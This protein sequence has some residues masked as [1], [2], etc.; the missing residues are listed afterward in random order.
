M[1]K[2]IQSVQRAATIFEYIAYHAGAGVSELSREL[3]LNKSTV[4]GILKTLEGMGYIFKNEAT[5][6]YQVTYRLRTLADVSRDPHS[7]VGFARPIL[8][9]LQEKHDETIHFVRLQENAVIYLDKLESNKSVRIHSD[10]GSTMPLHCTG[11][12]KAILAW[13]GEEEIETYIK[14]SGLPAMTQHT[15]GEPEALKEELRR[16]RAQG[17]SIDNEENQEDLYCV[18]MPVFGREREV[19]YAI[20]LSIPKYRKDEIDLTIAV[21]DLKAAAVEISSFF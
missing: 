21:E 5:E 20:S 4:F 14:V 15:I 10:I 18:G 7:I 13:R 17:F 1:S 19:R 3:Q 2:G 11:V 6:N 12:G 8:R 16:V 9:K